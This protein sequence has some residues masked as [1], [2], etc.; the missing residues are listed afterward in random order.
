MSRIPLE[1][2]QAKAAEE[3]AKVTSQKQAAERRKFAHYCYLLNPSSATVERAFSVL[4]NLYD[5]QQTRS[6]Q[7]TIG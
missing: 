1:E 4:K 7:E 3:A 5:S 2:F 6:L